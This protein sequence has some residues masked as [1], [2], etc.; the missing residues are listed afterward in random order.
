MRSETRARR[1]YVARWIVGL[2]V[3][4]LSCWLL[5]RDL[6]WKG[7]TGALSSAD[8]RWVIAGVLA[9]VA[10]FFTRAWR[11]QA[12]LW[13]SRVGLRPALT[14]LL[15]GQV[16]NLALPMRSGDVVRAI[17]IGPEKGIGA[18]EALGSVAVEKVW[19]LLALLVCA[20]ILL[21]WMPLPGWFA[22]STWGTALTLVLGGSLLWAVLRWQAPLFRLAGRL[23]ARMPAGWDRALLPRLRRLTNGLQ[24]IR[25][26]G[27][28]ARALMWTGLTWGLGAAA[29]LAVLAAFG[30]PSAAIALFLLVALMVGNTA[31]PTPGRLGIFEGICVVSLYQLFRLVPTDEEALAVGLVLHLVV[32]GPALIAAALL[33]LWP[34]RRSVRI[35]EPA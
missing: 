24:A 32:V 2:G 14:A 5:A 3:A 16:V 13:Q 28:S 19:D 27:V 12:L 15:V 20:L 22:R 25:H 18:A 9:I 30:V 4:G 35:D 29:N 11:W 17:W 7:V 10:T 34:G 31:L 8:Y 1:A 23:L 21:A 26:P 6:D 33:A